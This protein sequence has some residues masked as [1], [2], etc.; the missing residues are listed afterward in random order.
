MTTTPQVSVV[1][2][3]L[4]PGPYLDEAVASVLDQTVPDLELL[5]VDDGS[6]DGSG[7]VARRW[8]AEDPRVV[9]LTHPGG[10]NRGMG[11]SRALGVAHARGEWIAFLD[12]DDVWLA[13]HLERQLAAAGRHPEAGIV[14]SP[15]TIWVT[16]RGEG[17]DAVRPLP[18]DAD[19]LLP[20]GELL[21]ST[22][23]SGG[24]PVPTCG[25]MF[26]RA[27]VPPD[28]PADPLFR[29]LFEDQT[30]VSRLTVRAPAVAVAESTSLYRQHRSSAVHRS[31][32]R[33]HRDPATLRYI[34]WLEAFLAEHDQLT[35]ERRERLDQ[36]R[37]AFEPRWRFWA[38]Y[39][40]RWAAMRVLP[41]RARAWLRRGR[42]E[43]SG[44]AEQPVAR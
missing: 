14:V 7:D 31:P 32:G 5:L 43:A 13:D 22:T 33:G 29:G 42:M 26:R 4:D 36:A 8:A 37:T 27:V 10:A 11:A 24:A 18:Y 9:V 12:G 44:V 23:F 17:A 39:L 20:P 25:L 34:R 15:A 40:S 3:F 35:P 38:W 2:I 1:M 28:G 19:V 16:W 30:M 21:R 6:R 41:A